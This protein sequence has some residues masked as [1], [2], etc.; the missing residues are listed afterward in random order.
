MRPLATPKIGHPSPVGST[1]PGSA[2][3]AQNRQGHPCANRAMTG[4]RRCRFHGGLST[5]PKTEQGRARIAAAQRRRW[6][7]VKEPPVALRY[8][9]AESDTDGG[10]FMSI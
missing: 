10:S 8:E 7:K 9:E 4:K 1:A 2:C 5:G 6:R 3:G